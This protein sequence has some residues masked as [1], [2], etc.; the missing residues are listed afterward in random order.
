[1]SPKVVVDTVFKK[2][3]PNVSFKS[4]ML[5]QLHSVESYEKNHRVS[6]LTLC[7]L[8]ESLLIANSKIN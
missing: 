4:P 8:P 2:K 5:T 7:G 1:M 6:I 3:M